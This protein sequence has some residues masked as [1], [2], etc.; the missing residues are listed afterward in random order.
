LSKFYTKYCVPSNV[1][2]I[3]ISADRDIPSFNEYFGKM[4]W[5]SL[6]IMGSAPLKQ[7]L[8]DSL[9]LSGYPTVVV[10]DAKT[11]YFISDNARY[12]VSSVMGDDVKSKELIASWKKKE[13]VPIEEA[14]LSGSGP[15]GL[16][17]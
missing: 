12:E 7:K 11:G 3:Y 4:P 1:E 13:A 17:M 2:V 14:E 6:P 15:Q 8:A 9:K 5:A 16:L 10:L